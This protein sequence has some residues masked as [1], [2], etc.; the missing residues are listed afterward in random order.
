MN[1]TMYRTSNTP[2]VR[3]KRV[4]DYLVYDS[5][6]V[7]KTGGQTRVVSWT[8]FYIHEDKSVHFPVYKS[9]STQG[10]IVLN[11]GLNKLV[12]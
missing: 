4:V 8:S 1:T 5:T 12:C 9:S 11:L 3:R 2:L 6:S 7:V 10:N